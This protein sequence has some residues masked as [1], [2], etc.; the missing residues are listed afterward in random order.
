[1]KRAL[2]GITAAAAIAL[3]QVANPTPQVKAASPA[4][5]Q[6]LPSV[7]NQMEQAARSLTSLQAGITQVKR[8][9]TLDA[10]DK[11]AG[12]LFYKKGAPGQER[13]L[14][15]YTAPAQQTIAIVG[16]KVTIYQPFINQVMETTRQAQAGKNKELGFLGLGY[17]QAAQQLRDKY[18]VTLLGSE[19]ING[20]PAT[21][22]ALKPK[23]EEHGIKQ[24]QV[25]VDNATWL[26]VQYVLL[27]RGAEMTVSLSGMK[28][29]VKLDDSK[30]QIKVPS[31]VQVVKG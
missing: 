25:W 4:P 8:D 9:K 2:L 1:M 15:E 28:P 27:E 24:I 26:P 30:F 17:G 22:L 31:G 7:L 20:K 29:N 16:D 11:S 3:T 6:V 13:I 5:T 23:V 14:L 12:T 19:P 10:T 18:V 21:L